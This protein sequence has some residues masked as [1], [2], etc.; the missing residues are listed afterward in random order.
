MDA[1]LTAKTI[2]EPM[3]SVGMQFYFTAH[4]TKAGEA[5]GLDALQLYSG[6][7][8][9]IID[10][11]DGTQVDEVFYFFA[12]GLIGPVAEAAW[13]AAGREAVVAGHLAAA[14]AYAADHFTDID[15]ATLAAFNEA[16]ATFVAT[17]PKG[18]WPIFD[19]YR[20]ATATS[21]PV[22]LAYRNAILLRELRGGVHTDAVVAAGLDPK[23]SCRLDRDGA[24]FGLH[25]Y[26]DVA[27]V[28]P[29]DDDVAKRAA[30]EADTDVRMAELLAAVGEAEREAIVAGALALQAGS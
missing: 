7:R 3:G 30:A 11:A 6:G 22:V 15:P 16:M 26:G 20:D 27:D 12:P 24:F 14:D 21:D 23:M 9:G 28:T 2:A 1:N 25:G 8:G 18:R 4:S 29:T 13:A 5:I 19:G 17:L 10:G